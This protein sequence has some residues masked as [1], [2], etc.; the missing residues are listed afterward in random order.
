MN[1]DDSK[2]NF[3]KNQIRKLNLELEKKNIEIN[4]YLEKI[5]DIEDELIELHGFMSKTPSQENFQKVFESKFK[6][7]FREKEREIRDLKN[8]MGFL[9]KEKSAIQRELEV[10]KIISKSSAIPIEEVREKE[11]LAKDLLNLETLKIE[12]RK[13]LYKQEIVSRNLR[14]GIGEKDEHI[15]QLTLTVKELNREIRI[16]NSI[17]EGGINKAI[18]KELNQ[19]LQREL[20]KSKKKIEELKN[21]LAKHDKLKRKKIK[22]DIEALELK[23]KILNL[24]NE[25]KIRDNIIRELKSKKEQNFS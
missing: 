18:K 25:L 3:L 7:E 16:K 9:R 21:K 5:H 22:E 1:D 23:D 20:N 10:I 12:L 8:R 6:F 14:K 17:L 11:K 2:I 4:G 15:Q 13:Q 19:G 24:E